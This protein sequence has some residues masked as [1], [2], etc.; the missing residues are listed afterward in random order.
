MGRVSQKPPQLWP[1]LPDFIR[2]KVVLVFKSKFEIGA[3]FSH[4]AR[5]IRV[6]K[7]RLA[8]F[9]RAFNSASNDVSSAILSLQLSVLLAM[10][11]KLL[12]QQIFLTFFSICRDRNDFGR[13]LLLH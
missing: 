6:N 3:I 10:S 5:T 1:P 13:N 7:M 11:S 4:S 9:E 2:V 8:A 12:F